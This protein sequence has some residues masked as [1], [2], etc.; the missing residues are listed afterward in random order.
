ML[1]RF[2]VNVSCIADTQTDFIL[3]VTITNS[4]NGG[5]RTFNETFRQFKLKNKHVQYHHNIW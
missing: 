2:Y 3:T 1:M 5:S 4:K